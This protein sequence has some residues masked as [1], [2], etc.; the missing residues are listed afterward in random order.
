MLAQE[1]FVAPIM[2]AERNLQ[3]SSWKAEAIRRGDLKISGP[4]PITEETPLSEDE[5]REY[6]EKV[7]TVADPHAPIPNVS[8]P[9]I[10]PPPPPPAEP[11]T[12]NEDL[13]TV[14]KVDPPS[15]AR[16]NHDDLEHNASS[17]GRQETSEQRRSSP[18]PAAHSSPVTF[19][20]VPASSTMTASKN[21]KKRKSGLR[22]VFR[23]MF[24][25]KSKDEEIS[26]PRHGHHRSVRDRD[27][28]C[29]AKADPV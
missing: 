8:P 7:H 2:S 12:Q 17:T 28:Q 4:F 11:S 14:D 18:Q 13:S 25:R 21:S 29:I 27:S 20:S 19:S 15:E 6:A 5:E 26:V 10:E 24:G 22:N 3:R 23:K 16:E 9:S 1:D